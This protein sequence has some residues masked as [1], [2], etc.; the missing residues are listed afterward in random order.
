MTVKAGTIIVG[1]EGERYRVAHNLN[2]GD[3]IA[4]GTLVPVNG[5]PPFKALELMP[6]WIG[7][8]LSE[9]SA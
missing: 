9:A 8:A 3:A 7:K 5:E 1:P 4:E 6:A 2:T